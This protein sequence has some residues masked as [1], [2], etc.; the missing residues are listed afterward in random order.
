MKS[1]EDGSDG[2]QQRYLRRLQGRAAALLHGG[3]LNLEQASELDFHGFYGKI[4]TTTEARQLFK[5]VA[6]LESKSRYTA[7]GL[8]R[9]TRKST[10][11][12]RV[13]AQVPSNSWGLSPKR[14]WCS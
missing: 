9:G 6:G 2:P 1:S 3:A 14:S 11:L 4:R 13:L 10:A 7:A 8:E 5:A 12:R